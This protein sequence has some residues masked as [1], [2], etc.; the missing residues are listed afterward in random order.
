MRKFLFAA[1]LLLA[2]PAF[3][4]TAKPHCLDKVIEAT[5]PYGQGTFRKLLLKVYDATLWTD[6]KEFTMDKP[7]ALVLTYDL[8][9]DGDDIADRSIEE[10]EK[11]APIPDGKT[12]AYHQEL[13]KIIPNVKSGDTLTALYDPKKGVSFF[14]ND[15]PKGSIHDLAFARQFMGIWLSPNT[16]EPKLRGNLLGNHG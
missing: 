10:M 12:E 15:K 8:G 6:A 9:I 16:S 13:L 7:F 1:L 5:A 2:A 14:H 4:V 3:A 11:V